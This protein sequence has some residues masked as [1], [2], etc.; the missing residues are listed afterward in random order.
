MCRQIYG[1]EGDENFPAAEDAIAKLVTRFRNTEIRR[2]EAIEKRETTRHATSNLELSKQLCKMYEAPQ[3]RQNTGRE[4]RRSPSSSR[5]NK[6]GR[7]NGRS[8]NYERFR[9]TSTNGR[10]DRAKAGPSSSRGDDR[11]QTK[12]KGQS[13]SNPSKGKGNA[14]TPLSAKELQ[15][16][17]DILARAAKQLGKK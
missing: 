13:K 2:I 4:R 12:S 17:M 9:S 7:L 5:R 16:A 11:P 6:K 1:D 10:N 3:P 8:S 14:P 15:D